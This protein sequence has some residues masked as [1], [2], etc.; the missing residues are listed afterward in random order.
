MTREDF[1]NGLIARIE[2]IK[3]FYKLYNPQAFE[4]DK[5][6]LSMSIVGD[7]IIANNRYFEVK[8][9]NPDRQFAVNCWKQG[10]H[11]VYHNEVE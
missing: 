4:G 9:N 10:N 7:R 6:Y 11:E 8:E 2:D 1:E 5:L 3:A